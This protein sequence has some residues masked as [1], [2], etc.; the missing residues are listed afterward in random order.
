LSHLP[1]PTDDD[2]LDSYRFDLPEDRI[3][4]R[5]CE[6]RDACRLLVLDRATGR[7]RHAV[8]SALPELLPAGALLVANNTKVA[9]VRLLG[10]KPTGGAAEFLLTTPV[11]L[12]APVTDPATGWTTAPASGLLRVSR[13]PPAPAR[14][15]PATGRAAPGRGWPPTAP[16][17]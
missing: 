9:P 1:P 8:F 2:L 15:P 10:H 6:K 12:L 16:P 7:I 5:P 17:G 13:P 11:A 4:S 14:P 3:A